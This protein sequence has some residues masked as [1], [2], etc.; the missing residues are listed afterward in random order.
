MPR[1]GDIEMRW[2]ALWDE[3][4]EATAADR[5]TVIVD[6]DWNPISLEDGQG[7]V[8]DAVYSGQF[9]RLESTWFKGRRAIRICGAK[10]ATE[11]PRDP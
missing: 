8:Q 5:S 11:R 6:E 3:L 7:L 10:A 1:G 2:V 9:P 4:L